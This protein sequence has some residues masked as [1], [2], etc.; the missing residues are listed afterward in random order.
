MKLAGDVLEET[1]SPEEKLV[2]LELIDL[3]GRQVEGLET[4]FS[5]FYARTY[6][7]VRILIH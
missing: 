1:I 2:T 5:V 6:T 7:C 4:A 3:T